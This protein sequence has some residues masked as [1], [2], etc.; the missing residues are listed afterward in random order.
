MEEF[1]EVSPFNF[2]QQKKNFFLLKHLNSLTEHHLSKCDEYKKIV[3][4]LVE[5]KPPYKKI[6]EVPFL[7][8]R[9]FKYFDLLSV[10]EDNVV[11]I[12][13]SSGTNGLNVSHVFLDKITASLQVKIL[14]R[15]VSDF[16]GKKRSPMLVIDA[17]S[18]ISNKNKFSARTA[19][20]LGFSIF[21]RDVEFALNDDMSLDIDRVNNFIKRHSSETI[22]VLVSH[23]LFGNI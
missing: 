13:T 8:V 2:N 23:L 20:I 21:G 17:K 7:P 10:S 16:I 5:S 11:K 22:L 19:G 12:M 9:L 18:T 1:D 15:I 4:K 6:E 14:S 3:D